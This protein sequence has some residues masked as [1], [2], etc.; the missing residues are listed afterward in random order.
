MNNKPTTIS[1]GSAINP[2]TSWKKTYLLY[3]YN[4][5][6]KEIA[7]QLQ[8]I[9]PN[10]ILFNL[11]ENN[12]EYY[13]S[14]WKSFFDSTM[15]QKN[16]ENNFIF[17][18]GSARIDISDLSNTLKILLR[19]KNK[20]YMIKIHHNY[21]YKNDI[22]NDVDFANGLKNDAKKENVG[23]TSLLHI[24]TAKSCLL[25]DLQLKELDLQINKF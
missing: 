4:V 24:W 10:I 22:V 1:S 5:H 18:I 12:L 3:S 25:N 8:K 19:A 11:D 9:I 15:W 7:E 20:I 17:I 13:Y 16:G 23:D 2:A 21:C 14:S 6:I